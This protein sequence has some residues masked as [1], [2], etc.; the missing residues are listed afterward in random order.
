MNMLV[1]LT[2]VLLA[3]MFY[4]LSKVGWERR[5]VLS[6]VL[7]F[8]WAFTFFTYGQKVVTTYWPSAN[9]TT[10]F[11][12]YFLVLWGGA[13]LIATLPFWFNGHKQH[14]KR[15][16]TLFLVMGLLF[17]V[18]DNIGFGPP[19]VGPNSPYIGKDIC[20]LDP[21]F[22]AED[23]FMGCII[24]KL[25][26]DPYG[27]TATFLVYVVFSFLLFVASLRL[28]GFKKVEQILYGD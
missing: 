9:A 27:N 28:V 5:H 23:V 26:V 21:T 12:A 6:L 25:G 4:Y 11:I 22:Y 10:F 7:G 13:A 2:I 14:A 16:I 17:I 20:A 15:I 24:Q 8:G 18:V 3:G 19:A 1:V